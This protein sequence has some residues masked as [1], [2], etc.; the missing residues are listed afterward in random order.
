MTQ[1]EASN[2]FCELIKCGCKNVLE[3]VGA[4][5]LMYHAQSFANG[6]EDAFK[7]FTLVK[8][9]FCTKPR[10]NFMNITTIKT[11]Y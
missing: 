3:G 6:E 2:E 4:R 9:G 8:Y 1:H 11:K 5:K 7:L 10:L